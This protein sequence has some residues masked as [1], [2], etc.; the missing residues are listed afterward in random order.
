MENIIKCQTTTQYLVS[1]KKKK[2]KILS[3]LF[4]NI[5]KG[6][7]KLFIVILTSKNTL[8]LISLSLF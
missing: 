3:I 7:K 2:K 6:F 5:L 8:N 4:L 1:Q